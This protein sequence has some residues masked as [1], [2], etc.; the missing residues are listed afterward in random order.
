MKAADTLEQALARERLRRRV[1]GPEV[2]RLLR[3]SAGV[4]QAALA[5]TLGVD[6]ASISRWESG[7]R[8]PGPDLIPRYLEALDRLARARGT[9]PTV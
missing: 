1:P 2:R 7:D 6:R 5:R 4:S 3:E 8:F 9:E